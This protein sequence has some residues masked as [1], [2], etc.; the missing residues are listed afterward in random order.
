MK[1]VLI[2]LAVIFALLLAVILVLPFLYKEKINRLAL[3]KI[4]TLVD[5]HVNYENFD[6]GLLNSF[7]DFTATFENISVVGKNQFD[8][9]TLLY[10]GYFSAKLDLFSVLRKTNVMLKSLEIGNGK[11][12]FIAGNNGTY[13]WNIEK[14]AN[15]DEDFLIHSKTQLSSNEN[16]E[17]KQQFKLI[18]ND[19][20][21]SDIDIVY[22]S[23]SSDYEFAIYDV[24]GNL[25]GELQGMNTF[26]NIDIATPSLNYRYG[27]VYYLRSVNAG[28]KTILN[29]DLNNFDFSFEGGSSLVNNFPLDLR[30]GFSMS[31]DSILFDIKFD[32]PDISMP[33]IL[34]MIPQNYQKYLVNVKTDGVIDFDGSLLGVYYNDIYPAIDINFDISNAWLRYP[35][36]PDKLEIV[37]LKVELGKPEGELDKL[38]LDVS[39]FD[40]YLA[41]NPFSLQAAFS[42]L[43]T[44]PKLDISFNGL[45]NLETLSKVVPLGDTRLKGMLATNANITG[46]YSSIESGNYLNIISEGELGISNFYFINSSVPQG[47]EISSAALKLKN[48]TVD[49]LGLHGR[50]GKSDFRVSGS[51]NNA[52]SYLWAGGELKGKLKWQSLLL[53]LNEFM[54]AYRTSDSEKQVYV[55]SDSTQT[56]KKSTIEL[57][58]KMH[59]IFDADIKQMRIDKMNI[60]N[61][62]GNVELKNQQ[63]HLSGL[64]MDMIGGEMKMDGKAIADG[65]LRP[66]IDFNLDIK[67]FDIK[68]AYR[69][70]SLVQKYMPF[71]AS[72]VGSF[73]TKLNMQTQL[74]DSLKLIASELN[75]KGMLTVKNL[76]LV[77]ARILQNLSAVI[78]YDKLNNV[79]VDNFTAHYVIKDGNLNIEPFSTKVM[80]Q[81]VRVGGTYNMGGVVDLKVDATIDKVLLSSSIMSM[82]TYVPGHQRIQKIDIGMHIKGDAKK[83]KIIVDNDKIKQQVINQLKSSSPKELE[84]AAKKLFNDFFN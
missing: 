56:A 4:N 35:E 32:V 40:M 53:D 26:L 78:E 37:K 81:P 7:P 54:T 77:D 2:A 63:L 44:D 74:S 49:I 29:A 39:Q 16:K 36:L 20:V 59:L 70:L 83:P 45:V 21:L 75:A 6:L 17:T 69:Q 50:M 58:D 65:R 57:P 84:D 43:F 14:K 55:K 46:N 9:D 18:L 47:I 8:A 28:I 19:I 76:K 67:N 64:Q 82:I 13:N 31:G 52:I 12:N 24:C 60:T 15:V 22:Q 27:N 10:F 23:R 79:Q 73:S 72:S 3:Q 80:Q 34:Q 41:D 1:K 48:E 42:Q 51:L 5:A 11:L 71:A 62:N 61:T 33:Q 66:N 68:Q 38:E 30:G 25:H